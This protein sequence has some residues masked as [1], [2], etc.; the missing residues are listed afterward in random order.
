MLPHSVGSCG[1]R[2]KVFRDVNG[3]DPLRFGYLLLCF[4]NTTVS[5]HASINRV[6]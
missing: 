1:Y 6:D 3:R 2:P 5:V 4:Q